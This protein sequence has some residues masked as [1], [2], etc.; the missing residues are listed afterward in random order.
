MLKIDMHTHIMPPKVPDFKAQFG[1]GGFINIEHHKAGSARM[2]RDDGT[3]FREIQQNCFDPQARLED[4]AKVGID[5]QVLSTIPVLFSYFAQPQDGL[6]V[7]RFFNDHIAEVV[8]EYPKR[9]IGLGSLPFQDIDLAVKELERCRNDLKMPGIQM[10]SHVGERNLN[11]P[12]FFPFY[13]AAQDLDAAVL[14]HP[15]DMMGKEKMPKYWLPWLVGMPAECSLAI[16]SMI[17]GGVFEKFPRLKVCFAHG[18]GSFPYTLGRIEHGFNVRPDL[19]A[20]DNPVNP[21]DYIGRL[22]F[23]SVT[24]DPE[25]LRYLI[26]LT[27]TERIMLGSDYPFPL[28][29]QVPGKM[30]AGM[31]DLSQNDRERLMHGSAL[32]WLGLDKKAFV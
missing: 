26:K 9:F 32:E 3:F 19:C 24:H 5:V 6:T 12:Y 1:Y 2:I 16:C 23:D 8:R 4:C 7:S 30:I 29:E 28:G 20:V 13:E 22:W 14:I 31:T 27:G 15:W 21:R 17:F 11:D 18:G 25:A 10:G